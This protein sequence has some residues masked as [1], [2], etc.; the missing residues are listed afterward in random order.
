[1]IDE[2]PPEGYVP[3]KAAQKKAAKK[4]VAPPVENDEPKVV[5]NPDE[6][7]LKPAG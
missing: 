4:P 3:K 7:P 5:V 6:I 1:M 2:Y